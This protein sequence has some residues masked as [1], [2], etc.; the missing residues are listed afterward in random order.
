MT[1][2][3]KDLM[4][5]EIRESVYKID[6]V[7]KLKQ[8]KNYLK[9]N[10]LLTNNLFERFGMY[11]PK[12]PTKKEQLERLKRSTIDCLFDAKFNKSFYETLKKE[13]EKEKSKDLKMKEAISKLTLLI[14][15]MSGKI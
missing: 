12:P 11:E 13:L 15:E 4:K 10:K 6:S 5:Q 14:D 7:K 2:K 8:L 1:N 9:E 3:V